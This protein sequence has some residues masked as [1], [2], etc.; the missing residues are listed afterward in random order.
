MNKFIFILLIILSPFV[1]LNA[2]ETQTG[3]L[4]EYVVDPSDAGASAERNSIFQWMVNNFDAHNIPLVS[5]VKLTSNNKI[6]GIDSVYKENPTDVKRRYLYWIPAFTNEVPSTFTITYPWFSTNGLVSGAPSGKASWLAEVKQGCDE[7]RANPDYASP[8]PLTVTSK[9]EKGNYNIEVSGAP[10]LGGTA[11]LYT[12]LVEGYHKYGANNE[13]YFIP[14]SY[15]EQ[16]DGLVVTLQAGKPFKHEVSVPVNKKWNTKHLYAVSWLQDGSGKTFDVAVDRVVNLKNVSTLKPVKLDV[17]MNTND[18][19]KSVEP[20]ATQLLTFTI[21]NPTSKEVKAEVYLNKQTSDIPEDWTVT[22]NKSTV[23]I[24]PSGT[25]TVTAT[26]NTVNM[27]KIGGI[28]L[29]V[30]PVDV[31]ADENPV[32][33]SKTA[34]VCE[35]NIK[36]LI[37]SSKS[38]S[39]ERYMFT[40]GANYSAHAETVGLIDPLY[41]SIIPVAKFTGY[42]Y[43][44]LT[45]YTNETTL[46]IAEVANFINPGTYDLSW[47]QED[48]NLMSKY[49]SPSELDFISSAITS[50][51]HLALFI[52]KT[53]WYSTSSL[54]SADE[55]G[56]YTALFAAYGA[57][58]LSDTVNYDNDTKTT[59]LFEVETVVTDSLGRD[60]EGNALKFVMNGYSNSLNNNIYRNTWSILN[61]SKTKLIGY[62][63]PNAS[64]SAM[65]KTVN[66]TQ[67]L[68]LAGAG[69]GALTPASMPSSNALVDNI[70]TWWL[71]YKPKLNPI[72]DLD[73][74]RMDFDTVEMPNT[75]RYVMHVK[76]AGEADQ[77]SLKFYDI[78]WQYNDDAVM[79][80]IHVPS[81]IPPGGMDSIVVDFTPKQAKTYEETL[82][83]YSNDS[84]SPAN[85][86][87]SGVGKGTPAEK[88]PEI[89]INPESI[90]F[91]TKDDGGM[92][93]IKLINIYN[94]GN[95]DLTI[96][97]IELIEGSNDIFE[98]K[99][100]DFTTVT[101]KGEGKDIEVWFYPKNETTKDSTYT[102]RV[103]IATNDP[104]NP[105]VYCNLAGTV[106]A[107]GG[108]VSV[109]YADFKVE[110][111]P[112]NSEASV[113]FTIPQKSA[114][115]KVLINII[116]LS[117]KTISTLMDTYLDGGEHKRNFNVSNISTGNYYI[118][119]DI[120][121]NR[122]V[123]PLNIIK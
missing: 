110:P 40:S 106:K 104:L 4:Y 65:L 47:T 113:T 74:I 18:E 73:S 35:K 46:S 84:K 44:C 100:A 122:M 29:C 3:V 123:V 90:T 20:A 79:E 120:N 58:L 34:V 67:K 43:N 56:K 85:L 105:V 112:V 12:V 97:H 50:N 69:L 13:S 80:L 55:K 81:E 91:A 42:M 89:E 45:Q 37:F 52:D 103:E 93:D 49:L 11:R 7:A 107:G 36:I 121:D 26:V 17:T 70:L 48:N 101:P 8:I 102:A 2:S 82:E 94:G 25:S 19:F 38:N 117:G 92:A 118:T 23:T 53:A 21:T 61:S 75:K 88:T 66:G 60:A 27:P 32:I 116:D 16:P 119:L 109:E 59:T 68:F 64:N 71:G 86:Y 51:K 15:C 83:I 24:A 78:K 5:A 76:N 114:S 57:N 31:A 63:E 10:T 28:D 39:I 108:I 22:L 115:N 99:K 9:I 95:A 14:R 111:N 1:V 6:L 62:Y 96:N 54:A 98:I 33:S 30:L 87:C 77:G 41:H 72:L